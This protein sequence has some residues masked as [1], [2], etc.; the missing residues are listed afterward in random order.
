M[1]YQV[2]IADN[3]IHYFAENCKDLAEVF[4]QHYGVKVE[5]IENLANKNNYIKNSRLFLHE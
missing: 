5:A 4:A 1:T 3:I 2:K